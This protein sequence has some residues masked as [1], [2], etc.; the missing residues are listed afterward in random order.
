MGEADKGECEIGEESSGDGEIE[1]RILSELP[2]AVLDWIEEGGK[3]A[4]WHLR[5][6][7]KQFKSK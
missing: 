3:N 4:Y 5:M 6:N 7:S 1:G 2:G